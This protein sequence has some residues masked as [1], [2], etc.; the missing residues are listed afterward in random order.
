MTYVCNFVSILLKFCI[1]FVSI[2]LKFCIEGT[3]NNSLPRAYNRR[4]WRNWGLEN[5]YGIKEITIHENYVPLNEN[6][7]SMNDLAI[8]TVINEIQFNN[9]TKAGKLQRKNF[10][11]EQ[12]M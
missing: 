1:S 8:L 4:G 6:S 9:D 2:L 5:V 10:K 3:T 7:S 12:S 11:P